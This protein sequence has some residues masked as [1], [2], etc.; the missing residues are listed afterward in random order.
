MN[1]L[2][3]MNASNYL[4]QDENSVVT[5]KLIA[6]KNTKHDFTKEKKI[7]EDWDVNNGYDQTYVLDKVYGDL[8][9]AS[10]T[11]ET[12]SGITLLIYST[13]PVAHLYTAKYLDVKDGKGGKNYKEFDAFCVETQHHPNAINIPNFPSTILRPDEIYTQTTIYKVLTK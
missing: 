6:V 13:E 7:G 5:G 3:Q 10:K 4:E 9:L 11:T 8:T 2:H 1:H 12:N